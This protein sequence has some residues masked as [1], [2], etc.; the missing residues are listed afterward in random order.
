MKPGGTITIGSYREA[1][2]GKV[3][4][5]ALRDDLTKLVPLG[6]FS[7]QGQGKNTFYVRTEKPTV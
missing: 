4:E 6:F 2:G 5:R 1:T 3:S 7:K